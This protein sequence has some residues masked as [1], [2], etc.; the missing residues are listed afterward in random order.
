[1]KKSKVIFFLFC[2]FLTS[3]MFG[4]SITVTGNILNSDNQPIEFA[5]ISLSHKT[6]KSIYKGSV[7]T[8]NGDF[9]IS[10]PEPGNYLLTIS[11]IGY[12]NFS[13]TL[14]IQ[15]DTTLS[16]IRLSPSSQNLDEIIVTGKRKI[17][18]KKEGKL[19]FN[20][21]ASPLKSGFDGMEVLQ[22]S[23]NVW[24][25]E[26]GGIIMRNE[27]ATVM[28]NGQILNISGEALTNYLENIPS[29]QI[30]RIEI[31]TH[32]SANTDAESSGGVINIIVKK[33]PVGYTIGLRQDLMLKDR[34][35][36]RSFSGI[37]FN[38][39][40]EKWNIYGRYNFNINDSSHDNL[41]TIDFFSTDRFLE[42]DGLWTRERNRHNYQLGFVSD[43]AKN[44]TFG[45][46]GFGSNFQSNSNDNNQITFLESDTILDKGGSV[47]AGTYETNRYNL[48]SNYN[49]TYDTLDSKL[50]LFVDYSNQETQ[51][52][53]VVNSTY[54]NGFF[55]DNT[56]RNR[57][58]NKTQILGI[59]ADIQQNFSGGY[60]LKTGLKLTNIKR[61]N[62]LIGEFLDEN[63]WTENDR[64]NRFDYDES[65]RAAYASVS[66]KINQY[67]VEIGLRAENTDLT[68]T[69]Y[70]Q[71]TILTQNY[72]DWFPNVYVSRDF[73]K[74]NL[75]FAYSRRLRRPQ[76]QF[77]NNYV[78][79]IN[80]FRYDLGN[81]NLRPEYV[82][83]YELIYTFKKHNLAVY[84][85]KVSDAINGIYYLEDE[86]TYYQKFNAGSQTQYGLE[87]NWAGNFRKWWFM[88]TSAGVYHRK[89][90]DEAGNDSFERT[91]YYVNLVHNFKLNATTNF[92]ISG[93]YR[94]KLEDAFYISFPVYRINLMVQKTFFNKK[95]LCRVSFNDIFNTAIYD[96]E[97]PF[98]TFT[99]FRSFKPQSRTVV[100]RL[101]YNFANQAKFGKR[102]NKSKNEAARRL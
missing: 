46:E 16:S 91:T 81:P 18:E 59:Q 12:Q 22:R 17:I 55:D 9:S 74:F 102:K 1:M 33:K 101:V 52:S 66:K 79:K 65:V 89:F 51:N 84:H 25:D 35:D 62:Q 20:V 67:F 96:N 68:R 56:E 6:K 8:L 30:Q 41:G 49:W 27:S 48:T 3:L 19:L 92:E 76:F 78:S 86:I 45:I 60:K 94:S 97:R 7:S 77:L 44:H 13:Q 32:L 87:Y 28:I 70:T 98:E 23:P 72:T 36:I 24:V 63:N 80:D 2:Q 31:Q 50:Q 14:S 29:D 37:N 88:R 99:S 57:N 38:Y 11:F 95:L 85:Q 43:I 58:T 5:N 75:S 34:N 71:D 82:D 42:E 64:S 47:L 73:E 10:I 54:E 21:Q 90:T 83:N 61:E 93:R 69:D 39:G 40:A 26:N 100:F 53:S 4:Q 15:K